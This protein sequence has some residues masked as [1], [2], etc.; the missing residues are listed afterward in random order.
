MVSACEG[1]LEDEILANDRF[2]FNLL[3]MKLVC[4][5]IMIFFFKNAETVLLNYVFRVGQK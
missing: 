4:Y 3:N 2:N 1:V 5:F